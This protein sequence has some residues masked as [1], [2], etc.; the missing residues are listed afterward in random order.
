LFAAMRLAGLIHK[1]VTGD[2]TVLP[3]AQVVR[4]ATLG[5]ATAVGL[6]E[7]IGSLEVGKQA[8]FICVDLSRVHT[9]PVYDPNSAL[10]YAAGRD[11]VRHVW[12][13][14]Q[15]VLRDGMA[16]RVD[17]AEVTAGLNQLRVEVLA[18]VAGS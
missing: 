5:G 9:Q 12:V 7:S 18:A 13:A 1:G 17:E 6:S 16:T 4:S 8:D 10:V 2:A 15:E 11:D 14:G 3:A